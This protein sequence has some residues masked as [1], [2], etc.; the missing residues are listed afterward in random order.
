MSHYSAVVATSSPNL[1]CGIANAE[2]DLAGAA[3]SNI[4]VSCRERLAQFSVWSSVDKTANMVLSN[5]D[6]TAKG[7]ALDVGLRANIGRSSG[8][9]YFEFTVDAASASYNSQIG[10]ATR[11]WLLTPELNTSS[12]ACYM[13][14]GSYKKIAC[15]TGGIAS[16]PTFNSDMA[17]AVLTAGT[18]IG[19]AVDLDLHK[20]CFRRDGAWQLSC[21]PLLPSSMHT[22]NNGAA[23]VY[24]ALSL[25]SNVQVSANFG[26]RAFAAPA[27]AGYIL[28]W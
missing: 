13:N 23:A 17:S 8:K 9:Y 14:V 28:G 7:S 25:D 11:S 20:I 12:P 2:G 19:I 15:G 21:N 10:L 1:T 27:P 3:V 5:G 4:Q 6:L 18:V 24:P 22:I 16:A 26:Q